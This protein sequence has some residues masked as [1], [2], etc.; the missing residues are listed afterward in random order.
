MGYEFIKLFWKKQIWIAV[1]I[2]FLF[3]AWSGYEN[4]KRY[5]NYNKNLYQKCSEICDGLSREEALA[6][7]NAAMWTPEK[8]QED[9][10][11]ARLFWGEDFAE[12][13]EEYI[14]VLITLRE[15]LS[16]PQEYE[17]F[18]QKIIDRF[19]DSNSV[20]IF[21]RENSY[22]KRNRKLG[23]QKYTALLS[24]NL[25]PG[26]FGGV[27][28][29]RQKTWESFLILGLVLLIV[30]SVW[31]EEQNGVQ[32]IPRTTPKGRMSLASAKY[33]TA[34]VCSETIGVSLFALKLIIV[35]GK[36]VFGNI[37]SPLQSVSYFRNCFEM[38]TVRDYLFYKLIFL[39]LI[40][41]VI[42]SLGAFLWSIMGTLRGM[43]IISGILFGVE[44]LF[45]TLIY[46]SSF[47]NFLKF[48]NPFALLHMEDRF[49]YFQTVSVFG[50]PKS[51][52]LVNT[53]VSAVLGIG[54]TVILFIRENGEKW[55]EH[56]GTVLS[57][58]TK[59]Y[60]HVKPFWQEASR[61]FLYEKGAL[62]LLL[63]CLVSA[64]SLEEKITEYSEKAYWRMY[65]SKELYGE[66]DS[67]KTEILDQASEETREKYSKIQSQMLSEKLEGIQELTTQKQMLEIPAEQ[68]YDVWFLDWDSWNHVFGVV[69]K[70]II[71]GGIFLL[72]LILSVCGTFV[73]DDEMGIAD[74]VKSTP[75]G[76]K[77]LFHIRKRL[78]RI[79]ILFCFTLFAALFWYNSRYCFGN[80]GFRAAIQSIEQFL[81]VDGKLSILG[82]YVLWFS[83]ILICMGIFVEGTDLLMSILKEKN[84]G[85]LLIMF[86]LLC[87]WAA[88][89]FY[90][91]GLSLAMLTSGM[92]IPR[93]I[94]QTGKVSV[95]IMVWLKNLVV[96]LCLVEVHRRSLRS[97]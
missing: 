20:S 59:L 80:R 25:E 44:Y 74:I 71:Q 29:L 33:V 27:E 49:Y 46:E 63:L 50:Y 11:N 16:Y 24:L 1:L 84:K 13:E 92:G 82:L 51:V 17:A 88:T 87:D 58:R 73:S 56:R 95:G 45:Y 83:G 94:M 12:R 22:V 76:Y 77:G 60:G 55:V 23:E 66:W 41:W 97:H 54:M 68:G 39:I 67:S 62:F 32:A 47:C 72:F 37:E 91:P 19:Q 70:W 9:M 2:S 61:V 52:L 34:L 81:W 53:V 10:Q 15:N 93:I 38:I 18:L 36:L 21:S 4:A 6:A 43:V 5:D 7:I 31:G 86:W 96:F 35:N 48:V 75:I 42:S 90:I 14:R 78:H 26:E 64:L 30:G 79:C 85:L 65:Y 57:R 40:I 28:A 69:E 89:Y 3:F 8:S